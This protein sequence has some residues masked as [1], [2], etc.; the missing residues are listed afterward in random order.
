MWT[1]PVSTDN[2]VEWFKK[3][4][5]KA[6]EIKNAVGPDLGALVYPTLDQLK[7]TSTLGETDAPW[8]WTTLQVIAQRGVSGDGDSI[9]DLTGR[10]QE[11]DP[12]GPDVNAVWLRA[13]L[14]DLEGMDATPTDFTG[15]ALPVYNRKTIR[16]GLT[17]TIFYDGDTR[18]PTKDGLLWCR[19][20]Y[21]RFTDINALVDLEGNTLADGM[22]AEIDTTGL[23]YK[24][25]AGVW[26]RDLGGGTP[27]ILSSYTDRPNWAAPGQ[28][29]LYDIVSFDLIYELFW[30]FD[31]LRAYIASVEGT[32]EDNLSHSSGSYSSGLGDY[33]TTPEGA[34]ARA[35]AVMETGPFGGGLATVPLG[36]V[37]VRASF[38]YDP[39]TDSE[40]E[41]WSADV[42]RVWMHDLTISAGEL[43][44]RV[45]YWVAAYPDA[46]AFDD[47]DDGVL[48]NQWHHAPG[49]DA[50]G[51]GASAPDWE[52]ATPGLFVSD[53]VPPHFTPH[54]AIGWVGSTIYAL[55]VLN[56]S[57]GG[58]SEYFTS[59]Q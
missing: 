53:T 20:C 23:W 31:R 40:I 46:D 26:I 42:D 7:I 36:S 16:D 45:E 30:V 58:A 27:D 33:E 55:H 51:G 25:E 52:L 32:A 2:L 5:R 11:T 34:Y 41:V 17:P 43:P 4:C 8:G 39:D 35:V 49:A 44:R 59:Y 6:A 56:F 47:Q 21:R 3:L 48:N 15:Y 18:D 50:T 13:S 28:A 12:K 9:D 54:I 1:A 57:G 38:I 22:R 10:D 29:K 37:S 24:R 14:T 19:T